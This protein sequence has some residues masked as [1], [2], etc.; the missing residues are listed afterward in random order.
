MKLSRR[1]CWSSSEKED[2]MFLSSSYRYKNLEL[3]DRENFLLYSSRCLNRMRSPTGLTE[4]QWNIISQKVAVEGKKYRLL[5][6]TYT[7]WHYSIG[8]FNSPENELHPCFHKVIFI[9][10]NRLILIKY[11]LFIFFWSQFMGRL[12]NYVTLL[13]W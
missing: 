9:N 2:V 8:I 3:L 12:G 6:T 11:I 1:S 13:L 7:C 4:H 10:S 5:Y